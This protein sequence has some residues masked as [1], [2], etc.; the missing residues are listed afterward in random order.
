MIWFLLFLIGCVVAIL[1]LLVWLGIAAVQGALTCAE[2]SLGNFAHGHVVVA[3][4]YALLGGWF[5]YLVCQGICL[6][7]SFITAVLR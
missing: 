1:A 3:A 5:L 4:L 6:A 2:R 7:G